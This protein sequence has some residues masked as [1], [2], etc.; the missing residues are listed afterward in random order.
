[1]GFADSRNRSSVGRPYWYDIQYFQ[2]YPR[3]HHFIDVV[4]AVAVSFLF[5]KSNFL[6]IF[7]VCYPDTS[8]P[9]HDCNW[10]N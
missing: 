4:V 9:K 6:F 7:A 8:Y 5:L 10:V 3:A 2:V 1:M